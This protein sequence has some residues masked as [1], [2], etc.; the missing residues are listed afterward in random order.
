MLISVMHEIYH[1]YN[2]KMPTI[3]G[4]L[5][6]IRRINTASG[7][8]K[9]E[10]K[11]FQYLTFCVRAVEMSCSCELSMKMFCNSPLC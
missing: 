1:A 10:K 8:F 11:V 3:A 9:Q 5:T 7:C 6:L 2:V 4:I